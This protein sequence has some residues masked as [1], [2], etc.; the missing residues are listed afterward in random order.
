MNKKV[1]I[2]GS[3]LAGPLLGV[4]L[5]QKYSITS[6][7]YERNLDFRKTKKYSGRSINLALSKR[8]INAL[9][10]ANVYDSK[11]KESL[12]PMYGRM[13]HDINGKQSFQA[14]G[15]KKSHFINSVSRSEINRVLL[16][17]AEST[18]KISIKFSNKC[19]DID[20]LNKKLTLNNEKRDFNGPVF[21]ADGY[22]SAIARR[23]TKNIKFTDISHSYKELTIKSKNNDFQLDPHALHIWPRR[24]MMIIALPNNDMTF[25][26]TLFMKTNGK[27]SF[28]DFNDK[29]NITTFFEK[30]FADII[31][32]IPNIEE[33]IAN[34][35]TGKLITIDVDKWYYKDQACLIG[36][37]AH[38]IVPFYGQ[39]MNASLEDCI[40]ICEL[41][42]KYEDWETIFFNFNRSRKLDSDA[43]S[44]LALK[45][46][47]IMRDSVLDKDHIMRNELSF[48]LMDIYPEYFI[49]EYTMVSFSNIPYS[50]VEERSIIQ[51]SILNRIIKEN[52]GLDDLKNN[53]IKDLV[54][55]KLSKLQYV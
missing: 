20:F 38:A 52:Y 21:G 16:N 30:N 44:N 3:G 27:E 2:V 46:Y 39:G 1:T 5:A 33:Y 22:R 13:I 9:K 32:L 43:I 34:N 54:T 37:S 11:F 18:K 51:E 40:K 29:K 6:T 47:I 17:K 41:I 48:K 8:G 26:C 7:M 4:L 50:I 35:P 31:D 25:T 10:E 24:N 23:I 28:E 15:N 12:I 42:D 19:S 55:K 14:Y 45:N 49:P 36:D 53:F